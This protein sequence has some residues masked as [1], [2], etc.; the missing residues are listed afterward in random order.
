MDGLGRGI[1][2]LKLYA[3]FCV[4][5]LWRG[6]ISKS[7]LVSQKGFKTQNVKKQLHGE[8][9]NT[10]LLSKD[11]IIPFIHQL[12]LKLTVISWKWSAT[13][14]KNFNVKETLQNIR[15]LCSFSI[16]KN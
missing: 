3:N 6:G 4:C 10:N 14:I 11:R 15:Y 5:V 12:G 7:V 8:I 1:N 13:I 9:K 16:I 2:S